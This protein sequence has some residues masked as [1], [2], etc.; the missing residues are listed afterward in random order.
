MGGTIYMASHNKIKEY[1][2]R[3]ARWAEE[4]LTQLSFYNN[5]LLTLSVGFLSF[6]FNKYN[7]NDIRFFIT[8]VDWSL[9]FLVG[10]VMAITISIL[11]GL[12]VAINRLQ[13]LRV[14][15]QIGLSRYRMIKFFDKTLD[16]NTPDKF[17]FWRK[18]TLTFCKYPTIKIEEYKKYKDYD[19][20]YEAKAEAIRS[21]RSDFEKLRKIAH[22][23]GHV[24]WEITKFQTLSFAIGIASYIMSILTS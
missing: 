20:N 11:L 21:I 12:F 9:T 6:S 2:E 8:G 18:L 19:D 5:L 14:T 1:K 17:N 3:H 13:D 23:L 16:E 24:T 15:R 10:S 4:S 22:N 7:F